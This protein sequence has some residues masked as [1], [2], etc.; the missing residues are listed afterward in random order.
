MTLTNANSVLMLAV[1]GIFPVPQQ[2][3]GF[4]TDD[5]FSSPDVA[6]AEVV[7]GVDGKLSAGYTPYPTVM[8]ITL[9]ADSP[10]CS[11]FDTWKTAQDTAREVFFA[12]MTIVLPGT[13]QK[14]AAT[15]G[16]LTSASPMP[17]GKKVLQPR[18][19]QITFEHVTPSPV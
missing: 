11:L 15:H 13:G 18:K 2:L 1:A 6:P 19:W 10:S 14:F 12:D 5:M 17:S 16:A 4:S 8:D 7:M 9:Q 3:Q